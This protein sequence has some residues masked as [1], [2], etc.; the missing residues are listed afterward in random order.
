MSCL[1][2]KV[3]S[4]RAWFWIVFLVVCLMAL[5]WIPYFVHEVTLL[6]MEDMMLNQNW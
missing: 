3:S 2:K 5:V 1:G 4:R 6:Q